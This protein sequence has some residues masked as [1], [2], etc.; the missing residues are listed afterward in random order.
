MRGILAYADPVARIAADGTVIMPGH[1]GVGYRSCNAVYLGRTAARSMWLMPDATTIPERSLQKLRAGEPS[2]E[3]TVRKLLTAGARPRRRGQSRRDWLA[4]A[5]C[6][7]GGVQIRHGGN[8]RFAW[9]IGARHQRFRVTIGMPIIP[10]QT[11]RL[12]SRTAAAARITPHATCSV[13]AA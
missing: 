3:H 12:A 13:Q 10:F 6:E 4:Q 11:V 9:T 7:V 2:A 8:H 1:D 5:L